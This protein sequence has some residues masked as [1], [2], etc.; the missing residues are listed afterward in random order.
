[1]AELTTLARPYGKAAFQCALDDENLDDWS[2]ML[3]VAA[4]VASEERVK[5]LLE[6]PSLTAEQVA[7]S[8]IELF[9]DELS[10]KGRNFLHLLAANRRLT[11]LNEIQ[12]IFEN[13][14][15]Q[16]QK[17]LDV[18]VTTAYEMNE[19][20]RDKLA[21]ALKK[22][23]QR[24]VRLATSADRDLIGGAV[25]RAGDMVIDSSVRAKLNK[26]AESMNS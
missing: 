23:L 14:K 7:E 11:L 5:L 25:V 17:T 2:R 3:G 12:D 22:R 19:D 21:S 4:A 18:F 13:L 16:Q 9:G 8:F 26:L 10:D 20:T 6:S 24:E 1:M 15:A